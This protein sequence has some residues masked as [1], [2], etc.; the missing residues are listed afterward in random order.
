MKCQAFVHAILAGASISCSP[1]HPGGV[2]APQAQRVPGCYE[3]VFEGPVIP[4]SDFGFF[5]DTITLS[6]EFSTAE[7]YAEGQAYRGVVPDSVVPISHALA[8]VSTVTYAATW[9]LE[10]DTLTVYTLGAP[11]TIVV[12][13]LQ[14]RRPGFRGTWHQ[15]TDLRGETAAGAVSFRRIPCQA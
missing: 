1:A 7:D 13:K 15:S 9:H 11:L 10:R 8:N 2:V 14:Y 6:P 5:P 12:L 3:V 4:R